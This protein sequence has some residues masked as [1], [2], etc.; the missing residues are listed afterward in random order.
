MIFVSIATFIINKFWCLTMKNTVLFISILLFTIFAI[1]VF[2]FQMK[3]HQVFYKVIP[4][5]SNASSVM[6]LSYSAY[7]NTCAEAESRVRSM[8]SEHIKAGY[9]IIIV[10]HECDKVH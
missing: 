7:G 1:S 3:Q 2:G 10:G 5:N 6:P 9:S 4:K 8:Y